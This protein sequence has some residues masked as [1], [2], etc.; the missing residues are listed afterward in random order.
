MSEAVTPW[1]QRAGSCPEGREVA[2]EIEN[3]M[4]QGLRG[5]AGVGGP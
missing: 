2:E 1:G 3:G 4:L 5:A